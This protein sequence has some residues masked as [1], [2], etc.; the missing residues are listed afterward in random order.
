[1]SLSRPPG[2]PS[3]A[4]YPCCGDDIEEPLRLLFGMVDR[5][6]FCDPHTRV[7][8]AVAGVA[9]KDGWPRSISVAKDAREAIT[10]IAGIDVLF[11]RRDSAGESG[12]GLFVLGDVFLKPLLAAHGDRLRRI[13]TDGSNSR[14]SNFERMIRPSGLRKFGKHFRPSDLQPLRDGHSLWVIDVDDDP[15]QVA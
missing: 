6:Y 14:G 13:I 7:R 8:S 5:V 3:A 12:S 15:G 10:E 1:M 2:Q 9:Q 11:Y 4:F